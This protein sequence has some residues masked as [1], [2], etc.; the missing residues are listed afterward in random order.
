MVKVDIDLSKAKAK[1]SDD[2]L[3]RARYALANQAL[4]DMNQFV[5]M[6]EGTLRMT[7]NIDIDGSA[8]NYNTPYAKAQFYGFVGKG[9]HRVYKYTTPGTS[10][11]WDL[12]GKI[13]YMSEWEK[14]FMKGAGW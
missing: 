4:A 7:A 14:A 2:R 12:R 9:G 6:D 10:R 5:P 8:I 13:R 1:L 11:R 3:K